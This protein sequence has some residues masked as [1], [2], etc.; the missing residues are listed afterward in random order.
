[1]CRPRASVASLSLAPGIAYPMHCSMPRSDLS[2]ARDPLRR[3]TAPSDSD[4][5]V[6]FYRSICPVEAASR[7]ARA[8]VARGY[9]A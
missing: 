7:A 5:S 6:D 1:M 9:P 4:G 3:V 8:A 2:F